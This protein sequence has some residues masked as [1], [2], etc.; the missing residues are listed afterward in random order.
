MEKVLKK[1]KLALPKDHV[2]AVSTG[3]TIAPE[4]DPRPSVVQVGS[5]LR[6]AFSKLEVK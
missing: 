4:S 1:H 3:N 6:S 2:V 5:Q